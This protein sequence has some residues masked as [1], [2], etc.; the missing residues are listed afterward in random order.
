MNGLLQNSHTF[1]LVTEDPV[2]GVFCIESVVDRRI[3]F[4]KLSGNGYV[5][6][7]V[8]F[9]VKRFDHCMVSFMYFYFISTTRITNLQ[10][11]PRTFTT[12]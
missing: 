8:A 2:W 3:V 9:S 7:P 4:F 5:S 11:G 6:K 1:T 10:L 12:S